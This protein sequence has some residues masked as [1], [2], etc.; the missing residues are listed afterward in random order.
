[1]E[2]Q[3]EPILTP[4]E[5]KPF[6]GALTVNAEAVRRVAEAVRGTLGPKG[7]DTMLVGMTVE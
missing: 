1:M 7:L 2:S 6:S 4:E 5:R 3:D